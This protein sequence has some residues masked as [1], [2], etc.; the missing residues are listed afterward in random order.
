MEKVSLEQWME[1][2]TKD[3]EEFRRK[4][5]SLDQK[6]VDLDRKFST[7]DRSMEKLDHKLSRLEEMQAGFLKSFAGF[8]GRTEQL[9]VF[10]TRLEDKLNAYENLEILGKMRADGELL[11]LKI[12]M[13]KVKPMVHWENDQHLLGRLKEVESRFQGLE[14]AKAI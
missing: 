11:L 8:Q 10:L 1:Q 14:Q 9:Q 13:L 4:F 7:L 12:E 3:T 6:I 5:Q 2:Y